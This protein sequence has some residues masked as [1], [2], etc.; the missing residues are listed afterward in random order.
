MTVGNVD[1]DARCSDSMAV[2]GTFVLFA[3][4]RIVMPEAAV[5]AAMDAMGT[6]RK[7]AG[8]MQGDW[9]VY[10]RVDS[11]VLYLFFWPAF[12]RWLIGPDYTTGSSIIQ[13]AGGFTFGAE[14]VFSAPNAATASNVLSATSLVAS[15][16]DEASSWLL[17]WVISDG[18]GG[19]VSAFPIAV[20]EGAPRPSLWAS[21]SRAG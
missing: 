12:Q 9:P 8:L 21:C 10:Q 19:W 3:S 11:T 4:S 16:P 17:P 6:Y 20:E 2:S 14:E 1:A 18:G 7:V 15:C 13:S 5:S